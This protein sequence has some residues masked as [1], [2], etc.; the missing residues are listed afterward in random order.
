ML[1]ST[2]QQQT[3]HQDWSMMSDEQAQTLFADIKL[4]D[5]IRNG[6]AQYARGEYYTNDEVFDEAFA[7]LKRIQ[8]RK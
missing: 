7:L 4:D 3:I 6:D 1:T 8:S 5:Y 2:A